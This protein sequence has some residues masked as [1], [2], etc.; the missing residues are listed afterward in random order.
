[1]AAGSNSLQNI[2]RF[3]RFLAVLG[4]AD[5]NIPPAQTWIRHTAWSGH[6]GNHPRIVWWRCGMH[7]VQVRLL[8]A[9]ERRGAGGRGLGSIVLCFDLSLMTHGSGTSANLTGYPAAVS[10][11]APRRLRATE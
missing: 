9:A 7:R 3:K 2:L 4:G 5:R 1:V 10:A 6:R 11:T 8:P